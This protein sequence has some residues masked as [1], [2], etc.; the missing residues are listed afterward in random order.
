MDSQP[1]PSSC[2]SRSPYSQCLAW[3]GAADM[4]P[5]QVS[6]PELEAPTLPVSY[7]RF[8]EEESGFSEVS[9]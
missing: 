1:L 4:A 9:C 6:D 3:K 5:L 2:T 8:R 7:P